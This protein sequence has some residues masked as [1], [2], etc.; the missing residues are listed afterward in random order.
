MNAL[1]MSKYGPTRIFPEEGGVTSIWNDVDTMWHSPDLSTPRH[2]FP[3]TLKL[4][5]T[6]LFNFE[7]ILKYSC[8]TE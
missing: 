5:I 6:Y 7:A 8:T 3:C 1:T 2:I 4:L